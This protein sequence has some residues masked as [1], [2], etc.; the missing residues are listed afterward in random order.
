MFYFPFIVFTRLLTL[1]RLKAYENWPALA[2]SGILS[3][4]WVWVWKVWS[5]QGNTSKVIGISCDNKTGQTSLYVDGVSSVAPRRRLSLDKHC[6]RLKD[7]WGRSN[8]CKQVYSIFL[9]FLI[10]SLHF[11]LFWCTDKILQSNNINLKN[12]LK[13]VLK[14]VVI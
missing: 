2:S 14:Y 9:H 11:I 7:W 10:I 8:F 13:W 6:N 4:V 5:V 1:H 12:W 3:W